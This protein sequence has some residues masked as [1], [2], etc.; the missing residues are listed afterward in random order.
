MADSLTPIGSKDRKGKFQTETEESNMLQRYDGN[1]DRSTVMALQRFLNSTRDDIHTIDVNGEYTYNEETR[2]AF[3]EETNEA[4]HEFLGLKPV[5]KETTKSLIVALR[6]YV[7]R[8]ASW[9]RY[10][11]VVVVVC[12]IIFVL[13]L[14]K[15]NKNI[16]RWSTLLSSYGTLK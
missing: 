10:V 8:R 12:S 1:L 7:N 13:S 16:Q 4:L 5:E 15:R 11:V 14:R 9:A 2:Y 3:N 6:A